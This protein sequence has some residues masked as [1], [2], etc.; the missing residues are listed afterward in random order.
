MTLATQIVVKDAAPALEVFR[1][2]QSLL[3]NPDRQTWEHRT[4]GELSDDWVYANSPGQGL[5]ALV[6]VRYGAECDTDSVTIT[7]D[8]TYGFSGPNGADC[9]DVHAR[10]VFRLAQWLEL[11]GARYEWQQESTGEWFDS[12]GL[13]KLAALGSSDLGELCCPPSTRS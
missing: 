3:G 12:A 7:F 5:V 4:Y 13:D 8:T 10:L 6:T 1:F 9:G 11:R 2:C